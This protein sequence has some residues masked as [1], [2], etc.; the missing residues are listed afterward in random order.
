MDVFIARTH[1][2]E[3]SL[4][5]II[6]VANGAGE[7]ADSAVAE[8]GKA[9]PDMRVVN[10][11]EFVV[12]NML[13]EMPGFFRELDKAERTLARASLP[14]EDRQ[15]MEAYIPRMRERAA[16]VAEKLNEISA[17]LE[18]ARKRRKL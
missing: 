8:L 16:M 14:E 2:L 11:A 12:K 7:L 1:R 3:T 6:D 18:A 13:G 5:K 17:R 15:Q 9:R 4:L 10:N